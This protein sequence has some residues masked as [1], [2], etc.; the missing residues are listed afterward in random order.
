MKRSEAGFTLIEALVALAVVTMTLA[1]FYKGLAQGWRGLRVERLE[2]QALEIAKAE[3]SSAGV[4]TPLD[5][6][7]QSGVA[8]DG[9]AWTREVSRYAPPGLEGEKQRGTQAYGVQ[10]YWVTVRVQWREGPARPVHSLE[11]KTLKLAV[12]P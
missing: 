5:E 9:M 1:A 11:L 3:L 4:T 2:T 8:S 10:A 6:G 7:S 12:R